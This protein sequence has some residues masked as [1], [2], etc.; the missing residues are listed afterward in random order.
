VLY[1]GEEIHSLSKTVE[2]KAP[3]AF[4]VNFEG[5]YVNGSKVDTTTKDKTVTARMT[6]TGGDAGQYEMRIIRDIKWA[7]DKTVDEISFSYNGVSAS[8]ELSFTPPYAY[9]EDYTLGYHID[10][11]KDGYTVWTMVNAFPPRLRVTV[12]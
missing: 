4:S 1:K 3:V 9:G 10:L 6:L 2:A 12:P 5:W 8:K 7:P 11:L